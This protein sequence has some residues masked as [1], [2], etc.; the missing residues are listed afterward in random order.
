MAQ[1]A[2]FGVTELYDEFHKTGDVD[3]VR[4]SKLEH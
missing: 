3:F 2:E 1:F 4:L